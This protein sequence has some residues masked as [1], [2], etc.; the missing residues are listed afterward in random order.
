[1]KR[2]KRQLLQD[3]L[4]ERA[5]SY[6]DAAL[7]AGAS[8]LRRKRWRR[9]TARALGVIA[10]FALLAVV[11]EKSLPR[12]SPV[13]PVAKAAPGGV[14]YLTDDELLSLFPHTPIALAK[15]GDKKRLIFLNPKD[16]QRYMAPL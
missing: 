13:V 8:I 5:A 3:V 11:A 15:V 9:T 10:A 2:D 12:H 14:H 6:R 7:L 1:M 4:D 16:A